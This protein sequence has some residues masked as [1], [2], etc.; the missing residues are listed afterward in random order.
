MSDKTAWLALAVSGKREHG[1]NDGY[2]D[3]ADTYYSWDDTVPNAGAVAVGDAI[4][5][6][7]KAALLGV[8]VVEEIATGRAQKLVHKCPACLR[9]GIK[10][11][12]NLTPKYKCKCGTTF[13]TPSSKPRE[14]TTYRSRH[15][16]AWIELPGCLSGAE[17]RMLCRSPKSQLSLRPLNWAAFTSA[18]IQRNGSFPA[19]ILDS[20]Q[21]R[22]AGGHT[23]A[24]VR[25][26][27][28]QAAFR[29]RLIEESGQVCAFTGPTPATVLEA[30]HLYSYAAHGIH[31]I[32]GGL[33]LR[34]DIHRLFD[35]G[36]L[37][38][39]PETLT[40]DV[41]PTTTLYIDYARLHGRELHC[42]LSPGHIRW[43]TDHWQT[44][45]GNE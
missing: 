18:V 14:V 17:L 7:D 40:I 33:L 6:W 28:G 3:I 5:V 35:L 1:G 22:L 38:V 34:R 2:A 42:P 25:V 32:H 20:V 41:A 11:R 19:S 24:T 13:D 8:S 29:R 44:H 10:A 12:E 39:H 43:L 26:R 37:A 45:R 23:Q 36:Q 16:A 31:H 4:A 9:T 21:E 27:I 15:D 30:A